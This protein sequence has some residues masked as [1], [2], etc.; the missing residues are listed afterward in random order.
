MKIIEWIK[1]FLSD[2]NEPVEPDPQPE[3]APAEPTP[4]IVVMRTVTSSTMLALVSVPDNEVIIMRPEE[5]R[6]TIDRFINDF[7]T[8]TIKLNLKQKVE[9]IPAYQDFKKSEL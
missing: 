5:L 3:P 9:N 7:T 4:D 2:D 6:V 1:R 8:I